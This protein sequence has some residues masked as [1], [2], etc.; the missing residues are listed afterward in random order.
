MKQYILFAGVNGAGKTTFYQTYPK[1]K[2]MPRVNVDE[3][4]RGF[5]NWSNPGDV[6]RAGM[7]AVREIRDYFEKG[8]SFNQ[9]TT[10]CGKSILRNINIAKKKGYHLILYYVGLDSAEKAKERVAQRVANGGHGI[11]DADIER[12][13]YESLQ[14]LRN[15]LPL[16]DR[17]ELFDNTDRFRQIAIFENGRCVDAAEFIPP[18]CAELLSD[19]LGASF[20]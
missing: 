17:V 14:N 11:P 6:S 7:Q 12:R 2:E 1:L 18:W 10:L 16:F 20:T 19:R 3:I 4:V 13:Y 5:G 8:V 9:E 15:I